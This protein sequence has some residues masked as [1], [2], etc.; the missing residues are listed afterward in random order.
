MSKTRVSLM[1]G[2]SPELKD[3]IEL[4]A[5]KQ[6]RPTAEIARL[7]LAAYVGYDLATESSSKTETRGRPK[8]YASRDERKAAGRQR[9]AEKRK[10]A[11]A[12]LQ[13]L[14]REDAAKQRAG[15]AAAVA[16]KEAK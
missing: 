2:M 7:A 8:Q 12:L 16:T 6:N 15:L 11:K 9:R 4:H 1:V 3:A 10:V 5:G 13:N 14:E